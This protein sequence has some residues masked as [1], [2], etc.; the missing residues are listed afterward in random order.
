MTVLVVDAPLRLMTIMVV[1]A[2][3]TAAT[4]MLCW[5]ACLYACCLLCSSRI[6]TVL[7]RHGVRVCACVWACR[8]NGSL[9]TDRAAAVDLMQQ[10]RKQKGG[11]QRVV[12]DRGMQRGDTC[13]MDLQVRGWGQVRGKAGGTAAG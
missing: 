8:D 3:A 11:F 13:S 1:H 5:L 4:L 9:A 12:T 6:F 10:Y 2:A 7:R